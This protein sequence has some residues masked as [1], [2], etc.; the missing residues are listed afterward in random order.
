MST[1][2]TRHG[3]LLPTT[4]DSVPV[5]FTDLRVIRARHTVIL[6]NTVILANTEILANT[7]IILE[8]TVILDTR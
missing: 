1:L 6:E 7:V 5:K 4:R 2:D 3:T 8:K